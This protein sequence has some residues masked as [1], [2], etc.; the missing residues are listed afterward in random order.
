MI[1]VLTKGKLG[2]VQV[3]LLD[4]PDKHSGGKSPFTLKD[5]AGRK[6]GGCKPAVSKYLLDSRQ[7]GSIPVFQGKYQ[8]QKVFILLKCSVI[9]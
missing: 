6:T 8:G 3:L 2:R 7:Q 9:S 1:V 5:S 4:T